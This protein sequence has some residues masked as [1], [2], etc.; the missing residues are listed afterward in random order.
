MFEV[1]SNR[2]FR[3]I[4]KTCFLTDTNEAL[5]GALI[6]YHP[7]DFYELH[8]Q[9][10][11]CFDMFQCPNNKCIQ[12][13]QRCDGQDDCGDRWDEKGCHKTDFGY[14]IQLTG[15]PNAHEGRVEVTAFGHTGYIC[16]DGFG[17]RDAQV[18]CRELGYALGASEVK[19][20]SFFIK[21]NQT[22]AP[23]YMMD[24]VTCN[25]D[26]TTLMDC[27]F[28]GWGVHNCL[29]Q[30]IVGVVCKTPQEKC[31]KDYWQCDTGQE[32]LPLAFVCDGLLDCGDGSDEDSQH[33]DVSMSVWKCL[34][35]L[36]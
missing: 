26:E 23:F 15:S 11:N 31:P 36:K 1:N 30:E 16:D 35:Y 19:G 21:N 20:N 27:D 7:C 12:R 3:K 6:A 17:L 13:A 33:C 2:F 28:S 10:I 29:G 8:S 9:K 18:V 25:G 32:C 34:K 14:S 24:D 5:T 22:D 4:D